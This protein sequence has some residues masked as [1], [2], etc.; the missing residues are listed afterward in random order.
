MASK[1]SPQSYKSHQILADILSIYCIRGDLA[2]SFILLNS[3][4]YFIHQYSNT[5]CQTINIIIPFS[6]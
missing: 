4:K 1:I 5:M 3:N 6:I 2:S